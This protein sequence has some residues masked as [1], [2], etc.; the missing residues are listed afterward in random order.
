MVQKK[1]LPIK[2]GM[3]LG[4][5]LGIVVITIGII[6]YKT[7][8]IV[9]NEQTLNYV[10]WTIFALSVFFAI[11]Q[12]RKLD[13]F[14]FSL[15]KTVQIGI[16]A[17]LLSGAFYTIYIVILNIYIVPDLST[18]VVEYYKHELLSNSSELSKDDILDSMT[19]T[20]LNPAVRGFIYMFVCMAFGTIYSVL[21]TIILKRFHI[22]RIKRNE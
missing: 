3:L 19:V 13:P 22:F 6:R 14:S 11:Y 2:T 17:G 18:Q 10:Y 12:F 4:T 20:K 9:R 7:G 16:V 15:R 1:H 21:S 5:A 8:M